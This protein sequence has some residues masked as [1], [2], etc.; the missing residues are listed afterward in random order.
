MRSASVSL[1]TGTSTNAGSKAP[2][3]AATAPVCPAAAPLLAE[4]VGERL[5]DDGGGRDRALGVLV[6]LVT[7]ALAAA[8]VFSDDPVFV[9][10]VEVITLPIAAVL[11]DLPLD[12]FRNYRAG[13]AGEDGQVLA[14]QDQRGGT[15]ALDRQP[16]RALADQL[17]H[18]VVCVLSVLL[19]E[20]WVGPHALRQ[21]DKLYPLLLRCCLPALEVALV[22]FGG[23]VAAQHFLFQG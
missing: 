20:V 22:V 19:L 6:G 2:N 1:V 3:W 9:L 15:I 14:G 16:P 23:N 8:D 4:A 11:Y 5:Q 21:R 17:R 18:A 13:I 10:L 12:W 7:T